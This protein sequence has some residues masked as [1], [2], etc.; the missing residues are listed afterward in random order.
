MAGECALVGVDTRKHSG[1]RGAR[2]GLN[3]GVITD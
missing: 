1:V 3:P 2:L